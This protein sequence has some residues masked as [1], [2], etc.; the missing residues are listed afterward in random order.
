MKGKHSEVEDIKILKCS[1]KIHVDIINEE[2]KGISSEE[3]EIGIPNCR[4]IIR[5]EIINEDVKGWKSSSKQQEA[6]PEPTNTKE[7]ICLE[8][9]KR[10]VKRSALEWDDFVL[11]ENLKCLMYVDR[12][13]RGYPKKDKLIDELSFKNCVRLNIKT[14]SKLFLG[15]THNKKAYYS[16]R[17]F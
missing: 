6:P 16:F 10:K 11:Q 8:H 17:I 1:R 4:R 14:T 13:S 9:M 12:S 15:I 2:M 7:E 5:V 3:E